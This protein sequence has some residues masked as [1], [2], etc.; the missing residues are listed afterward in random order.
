MS[1]CVLA[2]LI[3]FIAYYKNAITLSAAIVA[4]LMLAYA[5]FYDL[6]SMYL[7]ILSFFLISIIEKCTKK[8][9]AFSLKYVEKTS[10]RDIV[11]IIANGGIAT[12]CMIV[13]SLT[14]SSVC[15]ALYAV[16]IAE[17]LADST[18]SA[19]GVAYGKTTYDICRF[20]KI[21]TGISGGITWIGSLASFISCIVVGGYYFLIHQDLVQAIIIVICAFLGCVIDSV[22]GSCLQRKNKCQCCGL[23][24]EKKVH[25][26]QSTS[27][28]SGL[29]FLNNDSVNL[30]SNICS[31][32][33]AI[34]V[35]IL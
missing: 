2:I 29:R 19:V 27:Y 9:V 26:N 7:M 14:H 3:P 23:I 33:L 20:K 15:I 24:T 28:Y 17:A 30:I 12:I 5:G 4:G 11:Q 22:L 35:L 18:A 34:I 13:Y 25:C 16:S 21:E 6:S 32:I 10:A 31:V 1:I 8:K